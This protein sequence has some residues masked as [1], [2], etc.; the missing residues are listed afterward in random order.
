MQDIRDLLF[1][2]QCMIQKLQQQVALQDMR[3]QDLKEQ[4]QRLDFIVIDDNVTFEAGNTTQVLKFGKT[5]ASVPLVFIDHTT[6]S[7]L[8]V[9]SI[10]P[11][12]IVIMSSS[13]IKTCVRLLAVSADFGL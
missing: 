9:H 4:K 13:P 10:H 7:A 11:S 5:F 6:P 12:C 8:S 2:Q 1:V 3:I